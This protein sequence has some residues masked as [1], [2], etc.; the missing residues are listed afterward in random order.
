[1]SI[2]LSL[3]DDAWYEWKHIAKFLVVSI[4][5]ILLHL[6]E[7]IITIHAVTIISRRHVSA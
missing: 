6:N 7:I 4:L 1:M 2:V 5:S 3:P